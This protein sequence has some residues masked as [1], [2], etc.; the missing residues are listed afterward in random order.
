MLTTAVKKYPGAFNGGQQHVLPKNKLETPN[1]LL[2]VMSVAGVSICAFVQTANAV[3][4]MQQPST[5]GY[6]KSSFHQTEVF[7]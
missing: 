6:F 7:S 5:R 2:H 1:N 3:R 4:Q